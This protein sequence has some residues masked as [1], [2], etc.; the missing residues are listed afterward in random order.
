MKAG[1]KSLRAFSD[2][3]KLLAL[4]TSFLTNRSERIESLFEQLDLKA[5]LRYGD[6]PIP[7]RLR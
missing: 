3:E 2:E 7:E 6:F 4:T 5:D 1:L